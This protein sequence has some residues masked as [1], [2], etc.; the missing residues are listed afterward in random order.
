M[1]STKS[2]G[3]TSASSTA[4]PERPTGAGVWLLAIR[5]KT[6]AAG[7]VPVCVG[8]AAAFVVRQVH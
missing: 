6:L 4:F 5:P 7:A 8:V 1:P 3:P 2:G